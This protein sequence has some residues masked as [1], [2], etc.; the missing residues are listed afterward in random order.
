MRELRANNSRISFYGMPGDVIE[1]KAFYFVDCL[2]V[3]IGDE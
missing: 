3:V 2:L 1:R